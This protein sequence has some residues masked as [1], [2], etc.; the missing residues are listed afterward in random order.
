[1]NVNQ[2]FLQWFPVGFLGPQRLIP[3]TIETFDG[4][5]YHRFYMALYLDL[6]GWY[7]RDVILAGINRHVFLDVDGVFFVHDLSNEKRA[8][9]CLGLG[10]YTTQFC[11]DYSKTL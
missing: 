9:G 10:G 2:D 4:L 6:G 3:P 7:R 11:G 1:M 8:P 5:S